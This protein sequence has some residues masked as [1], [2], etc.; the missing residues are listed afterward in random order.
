MIASDLVEE[1]LGLSLEEIHSQWSWAPELSYLNNSEFTHLARNALYLAGV[2][3]KACKTDI[4]NCV[5]CRSGLEKTADHTFYCERVHTPRDYVGMVTARISPKQLAQVTIAYVVDNIIPTWTDVKRWVFLVIMAVTRNVIWT[6][7]LKG[8]YDSLYFS[9][10]NLICYFK[11]QLKVEIT[12][13]R[14]CLVHISFNEWWEKAA[15]QVVRKRFQSESMFAAL[16]HRHCGM[17]SWSDP[18]PV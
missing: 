9:H 3:F 11:Y 8:L 14:K 13:D 1:Q 17:G 5:R 6:A 15:N 4:P 18:H 7:C 2:A 12:C 10:Y 16:V